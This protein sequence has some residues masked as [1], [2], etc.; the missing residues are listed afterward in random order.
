M[1]VE[2]AADRGPLSPAE[3]AL[4]RA[5]A[6]QTALAIER[7]ALDDEVRAARLEAESSELRAAILSSV[8][9]DL[10]T[11]LASIKASASGLLAEG[12][13][14]TDDERRDVLRT[15]VEEADHLNLIVANLMDLA[16]SRAGALVPAT[17]RILLEEVIGSV[18]QRMTQTLEGVS[19]HTSIR[20]DLPAVEAD[21]VQIG[22]VLTNIVENAVRFSPGGGT[23]EISAARWRSSVQV[24]VTDQG[25]GI[26]VEDRGRVFEEFYRRDAGGARRDR[27]RTGDLTRDHQRAW[28]D[29]LDRP[30]AHG[31]DRGDLRAADRRPGLHRGSFRSGRCD[32]VTDVLVIDDEPRIRR[33]LRRALEAQDY[34]V[35][36]A[37]SGEEGLALAAAGQPDLVV[38]D[39]GL[40]D[41]DGTEVIRRL[42]AWTE[43]PVIIL[44]V[45]EGREDKIGALDAGADDYVTKPFDVEELLARMRAALRRRVEE[46]PPEPKL[47]FGVLEVDVARRRVRREGEPVHLTPNEYGLLEAMVTN[48]GKLLTHAWLLR[49]VWGRGYATESHYL[50]VYVRQLRQKLGDD[51]AMP[52]YIVT[53]P[54]VGYRWGPDPDPE[55]DQAPPSSTSG[56]SASQ[57]VR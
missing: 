35:A 15:V 7:A 25:P 18:L 22:Q 19:I 6:S 3:L 12:A 54:G 45:R 30:R 31:R 47:R 16:R 34:R 40:P 50:H 48:P 46:L 24:R 41:L 42:R 26:P 39:L 38:L 11:P 56:S 5:V 14:Y 8:T 29:D 23:I 53:E 44:S 57:G 52:R 37:D 51:A 33:A 27:P 28:R 55:P 20:P 13:H 21:P 49:K 2:R 32:D 1:T 4:V 36:T 10:R 43:V 17:Q 9:H